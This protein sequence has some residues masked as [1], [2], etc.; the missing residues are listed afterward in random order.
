MEKTKFIP[1]LLKRIVFWFITL[2]LIVALAVAVRVYKDTTC[3]N[4]FG[5]Y[6]LS[7]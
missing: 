3:P 4:Y 1:Y 7:E 5:T 6:W 2:V